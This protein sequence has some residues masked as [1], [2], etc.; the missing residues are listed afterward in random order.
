LAV[1]EGNRL[2]HYAVPRRY[3]IDLEPRLEQARFDG[4]VNITLDVLA[5]TDRLVLNAADL[6]IAEATLVDPTGRTRQGEVTIEEGEQ[7]ATIAFPDELTPDAGYQLN[8]RFHGALNDQLHGFY[9]STF[10]DE[11]GDE[12]VIATTQFESTDARRAFPCW[13]E[14]EFKATFAIS[15]VITG[16]LTA[17]SNARQVASED[18]GDGRHRITFAETMRMS[19]YLVAFVV[20]PYQLTEPKLIDGVP[21]RIAA[22]PGKLHLAGYA[23]EVAEHALRFLSSYFDIPYPGDKLDHVAVPDFAFGAMENLGC[24]T[25]R[26]NALLANPALAAQLELQRIAS[27]VAHE[28]AHMWFGDLVTMKWWNGVWLNEA[29]ATFMEL[30]STEAYRPDWQ[31]WTA[32]SAGKAAALVT[33]GLRSTRPVE[34]DVGRPEEAEAMF[35]VLTYQKGGAVLRMLEQYLGPEVFRKGISHYLVRHSF[36]NTETDDLW[37]ALEVVSGEPAGRVMDSWIRQGG[38]PLISAEATD[39]PRVVRL[40]QERFTYHPGE[41]EDRRWTV[42]VNLRASVAGELQRQRI[43]LDEGEATCS[44]DGPLDWI[45]VNDGGWGFYRVRYSPDLWARLDTAGLDEVMDPLERLGVVVDTWAR[46]VAGTADLPEWVSSATA[47]AA[48][49]DPDLWGALGLILGTLDGL[50]DEGDRAAVRSFTRHIASAPWSALG[51]DAVPGEGR[52]T[53]TARSRVLWCLGLVGRDEAVTTEATE[54]FRRFPYDPDALAP[55]LVAVAARIAVGTG[56]EDMWTTVL[57]RYRETDVPQ[58]KIRYLFALA[59]TPEVDLLR[60]TLDLCLTADVRSQDAPFLIASVLQNR[61]GATMGWSWVEEH[62]P[63]LKERFPS[64]LLA[65]VLEGVT[66]IVDADPAA[67]VRAFCAA[68]EMPLTGLRMDQVLERLD[69]N[70][71]LARRLRSTLASPLSVS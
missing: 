5:A 13:D 58:D 65:R 12:H 24:V 43:L 60:R 17:L 19:T 71:A 3:E 59:E 31:V 46:V 30:T 1:Q 29:F 9:L 23:E 28:T 48:D 20:G 35:D 63:V 21:L 67:R 50:G 55:D 37:E 14:P 42:P 61:H 26:E 11:A 39:D 32:F 33:D 56:D 41:D 22:V 68:N 10:R 64:G 51:W 47:V 15:L 52:R 57:G 27:V 62:W 16:G 6:T 44:F 4:L 7:R 8:L 66:T 38:Y 40:R 2:P 49:P 69:L 54:R 70:V 34:S 53:A 45:V 18:L 25:Y 36:E